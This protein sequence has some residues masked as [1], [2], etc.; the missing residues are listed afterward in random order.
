MRFRG[1]IGN[2]A[3][4]AYSNGEWLVEQLYAPPGDTAWYAS[5]PD[6]DGGA[7]PKHTDAIRACNR[8]MANR[9][10]LSL[11]IT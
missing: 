2:A 6:Y 5:G 11:P 1:W 3:G 4:T 7:Y 10:P 8:E 9:L